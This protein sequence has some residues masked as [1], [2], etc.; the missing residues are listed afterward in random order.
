MPIDALTPVQEL[1]LAA[2]LAADVEQRGAS[3]IF[4][5]MQ[6]VVDLLQL[7]RAGQI[8]YLRNLVAA[9]RT[10]DTDRQAALPTERANED[11]RLVNDIADLDALDTEL[12]T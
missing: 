5:A 3:T 6:L 2:Y 11:T 9:S 12:S 1:R 8:A 10:A 7:S 4:E